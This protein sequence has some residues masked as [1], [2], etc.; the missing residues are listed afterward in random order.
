[1]DKYPSEDMTYMAENYKKEP[2]YVDSGDKVLIKEET[3]LNG[4]QL[5]LNHM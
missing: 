4:A 5:T 2:V 1:M 3:T